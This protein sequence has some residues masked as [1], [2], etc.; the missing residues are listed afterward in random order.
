MNKRYETATTR[1]LGYINSVVKRVYDDKGNFVKAMFD[2]DNKCYIVDSTG[3]L[4]CEGVPVNITYGKA[5][6]YPE[7]RIGGVTVK[8]YHIALLAS[9]ATFYDKFMESNSNVVN[10]TVIHRLVDVDKIVASCGYYGWVTT[11]STTPLKQVA[12]NPA[13][14]ELVTNSENIRHSHFVKS[15]GLENMFVS[16]KDIGVLK[17][18]LTTLSNIDDPDACRLVRAENRA[19]VVNFYEDKGIIIDFEQ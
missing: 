6:I 4:T 3:V 19:K 11:F 12:I 1:V 5:G 8:A 10:H 13:Y 14:L 17:E 15:Y 7:Y 9:D 16:A 2:F 18:S